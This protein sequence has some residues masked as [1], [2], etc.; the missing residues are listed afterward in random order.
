VPAHR[1]ERK[2]ADVAHELKIRSPPPARRRIV[3][4]REDEEERNHLVQQIRAS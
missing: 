1:G 2:F 3:E 4:L